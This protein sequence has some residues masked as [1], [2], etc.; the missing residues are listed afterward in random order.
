V[1]LRLVRGL[2]NILQGCKDFV[3]NYADDCTVFS[4]D[5][6]KTSRQSSL[7]CPLLALLFLAQSVFFGKSSTIYLGFEYSDNGVAPSP[8]KTKTISTWPVPVPFLAW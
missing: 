8:E 1:L 2:D 5:T 3:D 7:N 6:F 4:N